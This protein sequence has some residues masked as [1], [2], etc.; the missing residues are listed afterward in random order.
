VERGKVMLHD[1]PYAR[2]ICNTSFTQPRQEENVKWIKPIEGSFKY[3]VDA[4][5]SQLSNRVRT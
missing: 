3:N 2:R 4:S 5:F 1:L